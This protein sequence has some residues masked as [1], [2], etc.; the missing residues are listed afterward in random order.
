[1]SESPTVSVVIVSHGRPEL[2]RRAA[3]GVS[4]LFHRPFE[5]VVVADQ[6]GLV[7]IS[8]LPFAQWI[9]TGH[10]AEANISAA[11]NQAAGLAAGEILAFIDDD[12]VPEPTWLNHLTAPFAD[13][14][15]MAT[16]GTV[17][18]R[19]GISVQW[20]QRSVDA[21]G[22]AHPVNGPLP[23]GQAVKLEGTNMAIRRPA[24][25]TLGG[26]DPGFTFFLDET[27]LAWR[28]HKAGM[29]AGFAPL[30]TVH[31]GYAESLRRN[32]GRIPRSLFQ[33]GA[34]SV[35]YLRKHSD[36]MD[37]RLTEILQEQ[38]ERVQR[39]VRS[40]QIDVEEMRRLL[41]DLRAGME[42]G[43]SAEM[44]PPQDLA[45]PPDFV[46]LVGGEAPEPLVLSGRWFQR[47]R[48]METARQ[49][50]AEGRSS[51]VFLLAP[52]VR[53]HRVR[54]TRSGVWLQSGGLFGPSLRDQPRFRPWGFAARIAAEEARLHGIRW[55]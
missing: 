13:P 49:A 1:M 7:A 33:I 24:L 41:D 23:V 46:P 20:G 11:R 39:F 32:A 30:A 42:A 2:L 25:Q 47:R 36:R 29:R 53:A 38:S 6:A 40:G 14:E 17:L 27:D 10:Q 35:I 52:T 44:V 16:T 37:Q 51:S 4:Q 45:P 9:K 34:S 26:F 12:A 5:L 48:L 55:P 54:F 22:V 19:N 31:H 28:L 21:E 43:R 15:V 50:A 3:I 8:D 18:G